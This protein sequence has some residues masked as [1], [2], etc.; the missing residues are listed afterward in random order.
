M[1]SMTALAAD[2]VDVNGSGRYA[3]DTDVVVGYQDRISSPTWK[4]L[5]PGD[6]IDNQVALQ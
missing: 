5:M 1:S 2:S 6:T 3:G 4:E